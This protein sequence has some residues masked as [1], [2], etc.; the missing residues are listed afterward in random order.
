M[1]NVKIV[2]IITDFILIIT[3]VIQIITD[4]ILMK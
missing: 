2:K 1:I 4:F 3:E